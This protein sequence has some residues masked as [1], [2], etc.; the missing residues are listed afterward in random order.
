MEDL[1]SKLSTKTAITYEEKPMQLLSLIW[2]I[3]SMIGMF[4]AFLPLLGWMN[5]GN[6][7]FASIGLIISIV[8]AVTGTGSKGFSIAGVI[9]CAV[10]ILVGVLRLIIGGGLL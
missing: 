8:A 5:W 9:M 3:L 4:I 2:G 1:F 10:A 7:P 6:I